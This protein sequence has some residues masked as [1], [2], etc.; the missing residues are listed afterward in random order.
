MDD[1]LASVGDRRAALTHFLERLDD[2]DRTQ[3]RRMLSKG[4]R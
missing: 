1:A 4:S 3:L 2:E